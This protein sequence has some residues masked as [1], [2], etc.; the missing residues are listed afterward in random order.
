[1][2]TLRRMQLSRT[3]LCRSKHC[4]EALLFT[5]HRLPVLHARGQTG[6]Q[7]T[8]RSKLMRVRMAEPRHRDPREGPRAWPS[9]RRAREPPWGTS[10][11]AAGYMGP[12]YHCRMN[13]AGSL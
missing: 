1:M 9:E 7:H 2:P 10:E 4:G 6:L 13:R 3:H 5:R 8:C 12:K 11:R